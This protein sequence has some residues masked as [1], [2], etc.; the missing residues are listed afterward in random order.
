MEKDDVPALNNTKNDSIVSEIQEII[1]EGDKIFSPAWILIQII[2]SIISVVA[3][4]LSRTNVFEEV[5]YKSIYKI[6]PSYHLQSFTQSQ[7]IH[8][9][10]EPLT[11]VYYISLILLELVN[12]YI[13]L[14]LISRRNKH[15]ERTRRLYNALADYIDH[16]E[17]KGKNMWILRELVTREKVEN[18]NK[19]VAGW[20]IL[21]IIPL[22]NIF[23]LPYIYH[24]LTRDFFRHSKYE[25]LILKVISDSLDT[26]LNIM[27]YP[28]RDTV[29]YFLLSIVTFG[30]AGIYWLY[31]LF[32]DPNKHF[33]EHLVIEQ[34]ILNILK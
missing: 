3:T 25:E 19:N 8:M 29:M 30:I 4:F 26:N 23:A 16:I 10:P 21:S 27:E 1:T 24:F 11:L 12:I 20:T 22:I 9:T 2:L 15:L 34:K 18:G 17:M 33:K 28:D 32:N 13:I 14:S 7:N 5:Y 31:T 6:Y